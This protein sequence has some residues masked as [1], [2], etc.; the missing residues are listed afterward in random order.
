MKVGQ[1]KQA[2]PSALKPIFLEQADLFLPSR[3]LSRGH[4]FVPSMYQGF[5]R[6][7]EFGVYF[8]CDEIVDEYRVHASAVRYLAD[9]VRLRSGSY[10]R[11][12]K[13][14]K[15]HEEFVFSGGINIYQHEVPVF[16]TSF[17]GEVLICTGK[18]W[19]GV[20]PSLLQAGDGVEKLIFG[21]YGPY[22][23]RTLRIRA[24]V[25]GYK[26][27]KDEREKRQRNAVHEEYMRGKGDSRE[28]NFGTFG[29]GGR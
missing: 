15:S 23:D 12:G 8:S 7:K 22:E 26:H 18:I 21:N 10:A 20:L 24:I 25:R 9:V 13:T 17:S 19:T 4:I 5:T 28:A 3:P 16:E 2:R 29:R 6:L 1:Q 11:E 14:R 27:Q